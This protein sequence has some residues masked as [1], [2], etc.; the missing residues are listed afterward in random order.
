MNQQRSLSEQELFGTNFGFCG[1]VCKLDKSK[2][3][4]ADCLFNYYSEK[5]GIG[6]VLDS[7]LMFKDEMNLC[8]LMDN[9]ILR[10]GLFVR[11]VFQ[12]NFKEW[13]N[14]VDGVFI[15]VNEWIVDNWDV[16]KENYMEMLR[17]DEVDGIDSKNEI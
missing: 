3:Y 13:L 14:C 9:G 4:C 17:L 7:D 1:E 6:V 11:K 5:H 2:D 10:E 12:Y 8:G 16:A 15:G